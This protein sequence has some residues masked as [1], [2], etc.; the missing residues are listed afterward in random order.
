[1]HGLLTEMK[2]ENSAALNIFFK[3]IF[4]RVGRSERV[5]KATWTSANTRDVFQSH[6]M[7]W[8]VFGEAHRTV[9]QQVLWLGG[10]HDRQEA[11]HI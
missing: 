11:L 5:L 6:G 1:M 9:L 2:M 10:R 7:T 3:H 8:E 4:S